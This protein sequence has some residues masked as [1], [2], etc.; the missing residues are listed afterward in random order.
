MEIESQNVRIYKPE[1]FGQ[2]DLSM[3]IQF[4][5]IAIT[6][7]MSEAQGPALKLLSLPGRQTSAPAIG[8]QERGPVEAIGPGWRAAKTSLKSKLT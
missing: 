6:E 2:H 8:A 3:N 7:E 1:C 4:C 5:Y